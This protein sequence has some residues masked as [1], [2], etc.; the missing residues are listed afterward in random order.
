MNEFE[1]PQIPAELLQ[2]WP[3]EAQD[4]IG[5]LQTLLLLQHSQL[6]ELKARLDQNSQ[7]S[8]KPPSSDPPFKR[9]P[10]KAKAKSGQPKGGQ[11]GHTQHIRSLLPTDEVDHLQAWRP[12]ECEQCHTPL[13]SSDQLGQPLRHQVWEIEPV[14]AQVTEHQFYTCEC[15]TCGWLNRQPHPSTVPNGNFGPRLTGTVATLHGRYRLSLRE[16]QALAQ[17]L[18]QVQMSLGAVQDSCY[19][20]SQ[21]LEQPYLAAQQQ[22]QASSETNVDET[23]WYKQGQR[24]WLWVAVSAVASVYMI[25]TSRSRAS[26]KALVGEKY[27]G[28]VG[29]DRYNAYY[30]LAENQHQLCWAHLIRNLRGLGQRAGP[31]AV[32]S[33]TGL[34]LS[35]QLFEVWHEFKA[36]GDE[37]ELRRGEL[38]QRVEPIRCEFKK[39]LEAGQ[40]LPDGKVKAFSGQLLKLEER[41]W[42]FVKVPRVEPTNNA[43]ERALRGAVIW[44]KTCFG[45][46]SDKGCRFVERMLTMSA[47]CQIHRRNLLDLLT[48]S[49]TAHW[50]GQAAPSLFST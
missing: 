6:L 30:E 18:W 14:R 35:E 34:A 15:S 44:P 29:S 20:V 16:V 2:S 23:G 26:F 25:A 37:R 40:R 46:Q 5:Q 47:T 31:A 41:L 49:L 21:A 9:P 39:L 17:D 33:E 48:E 19:K 28:V 38:A 27:G 7:N 4:F 22:M 43:A 10:K 42:V 24:A 1:V 12:S 3:K 8:G 36:Q 50:S 13:R 45:S 11:V 32:W